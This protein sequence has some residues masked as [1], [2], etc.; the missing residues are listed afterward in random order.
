VNTADHILKNTRA[1]LDI[2]FS[3]GAADG[4]VTVTVTNA[5]G[6]VVSSGSAS[7]VSGGEYTFA[8]NPQPA[9][10]D[11][12]VTWAGSWG[13]VAQSIQ[14]KAEIVGAYLFT[15]AQARSFDKAALANTTL[16]S[17]SLIRE[18]RAG[19][20]DFFEEVCGV[21]FVPRYGR[22]VVDGNSGTDIWLTRPRVNSVLAATVDAVAISDLSAVV[23]YDYGMAYRPSSWT[24]VNRRGVIV[25]YE[26]GYTQPPY[27]IHLAALTYLRYL[28]VASEL[29]DRTVMF[30]NELGT[31]R[32]AVAGRN[33]PT[34]IPSVDAALIRHDERILIA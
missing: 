34:G 3:A 27:D 2:T 9:V 11:L 29:S 24:A 26:H 18:A 30:T 14:S 5:S 15:L 25:E 1:V 28:L 17:D 21:S 33:Y 32:N 8:L 19:I 10:A 22:D 16:Y 7:Q 12:T 20:T 13:G 31:I 4:A 6:T 23:V